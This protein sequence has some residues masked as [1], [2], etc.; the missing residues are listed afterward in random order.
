VTEV[1]SPNGANFISKAFDAEVPRNGA[2]LESSQLGEPTHEA[3]PDPF[4]WRFREEC[5][6]R[7]LFASPEEVRQTIEAWRVED[8]T[9]RPHRALGQQTPSS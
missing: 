9:E 3:F 5:L 1:D 7:P 8:D 6:D 2:R 4:N